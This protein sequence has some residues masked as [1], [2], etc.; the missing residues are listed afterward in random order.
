MD[1]DGERNI[2]RAQ[3]LEARALTTSMPVVVET[4]ALATCRLVAPIP[5]LVPLRQH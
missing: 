2:A 4:T 3:R 5:Q 1:R